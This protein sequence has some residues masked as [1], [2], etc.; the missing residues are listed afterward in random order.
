MIMISGSTTGWRSLRETMIK[1][2][3]LAIAPQPEATVDG[4]SVIII[5]IIIIIIVIIV[6][7]IIIIVI[8]VIIVIINLIIIMMMLGY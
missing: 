3:G 5:V 8:I 2:G 7:I 1:T 4:E 6:I